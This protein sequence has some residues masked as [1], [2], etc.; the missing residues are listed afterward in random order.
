MKNAI[1]VTVGMCVRNCDSTLGEAMESV[2]GLDFPRELM[3]IIIVDD[4][5]KDSTPLLIKEYSSKIG[6]R[7]KVFS[8]RWRGLGY[9]RNVVAKNAEGR[10]ILWVDGDMI[11]SR[12]FLGKLFEYMEMHPRVAI[13]KGKQALQQGS[14]LLATLEGFS[15]AA[16]RM[17]DYGS[18][19]T[20]AKALGTGGAIYRLEAIR[21]AGWFDE[22]LRGY[23]EDL[24]IEIRIRSAGWKLAT[25]DTE[26][27]DYERC[28]LAWKSLWGRYQ[29][30]GYYTHYFLHKHGNLLKHY[31]MFPPA[32]FLTGLIQAK[33]L[34]KLTRIRGVF[35]MPLQQ[36]F[37]MTAWYFGF[38]QS[39]LKGYQPA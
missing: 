5:S 6:M 8:Q 38:A 20:R 36:T 24:D 14:N 17:V 15:R 28:R 34:F 29:L 33:V 10:Y 9:S 7:V 1:V 3:E 2:M 4:G 30:R 22:K 21:Q 31:K 26:F 25:I 18:Q 13:A 12:D 19:K 16:S 35:L 39:H 27:L 32:A 11:L 37:K 23:G